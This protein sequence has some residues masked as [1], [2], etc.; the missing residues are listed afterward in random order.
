MT[1]YC[2]YPDYISY[3]NSLNLLK[4]YQDS[5]IP[6]QAAILV[7]TVHVRNRDKR[8][9]CDTDLIRQRTQN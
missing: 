8:N 9:I 6:K 3:Q 2:R 1:K 4:T 7:S 5:Q